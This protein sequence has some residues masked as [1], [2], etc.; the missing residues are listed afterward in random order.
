MIF[1]RPGGRPKRT[2][3]EVVVKFCQARKLNKKDATDRS[4][5]R[6][7]IKDVTDDQDGWV[8]VSSG[9]GLPG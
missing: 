8:N 1:H 2:W 4:R 3:K 9:T 7:F 6:K 5:W